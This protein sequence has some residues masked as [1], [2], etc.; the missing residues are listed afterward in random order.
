MTDLDKTH[1][2]FTHEIHLMEEKIA[3]TFLENFYVSV[4]FPTSIRIHA[5]RDEHS[6][7]KFNLFHRHGH[8]LPNQDIYTYSRLILLYR[9][10]IHIVHR[11]GIPH[12][13]CSGNNDI[14]F[15]M[16]ISI[17]RRQCIIIQMT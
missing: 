3:Y 17:L 12:T 5:K 16:A 6:S 14:K 1:L 13:F 15:L 8:I 4:H 11:T 9:I 10:L 2:T 7:L